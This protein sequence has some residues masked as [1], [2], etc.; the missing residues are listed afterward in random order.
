MRFTLGIAV[1]HN[2]Q[3]SSLAIDLC[4]RRRQGFWFFQANLEIHDRHDKHRWH[5]CGCECEGNRCQDHWEL[6]NLSA[7]I[8]PRCLGAK[9]CRGSPSPDGPEKTSKN[10]LFKSVPKE[11]YFNTMVSC[12]I[13]SLLWPLSCSKSLSVLTASE[14]GL[15]L[16]PI[17]W[18]QKVKRCLVSTRRTCWVNYGLARWRGWSLCIEPDSGFVTLLHVSWCP[19]NGVG[20]V[21]QDRLA[22]SICIGGLRR[23]TLDNPARSGTARSCKTT[24]YSTKIRAIF[25]RPQTYLEKPISSALTRTSLLH[26]RWVM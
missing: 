13:A 26:L 16:P 5:V 17:Y 6:H 2:S 10:G 7:R 3:P 21:D 25:L 20:Y 11:S 4:R 23:N 9:K 15:N 1:R 14:G 22:E 8:R 24:R 19:R 12:W 18:L